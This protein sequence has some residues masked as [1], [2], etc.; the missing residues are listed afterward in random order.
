[1]FETWKRR[2]KLERELAKLYDH[3]A[4]QLKAA[5]TED[6]YR[7]AREPF[8]IDAADI[9]SELERLKTRKIRER[10]IKFGIDFPPFENSEDNWDEIP[11][12]S[13][14]ALT[15]KAQTKLAHQI[16][17]ARFAYWKQW[18]ELLVPILSLLVSLVLAFAA[19]KSK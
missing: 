19:L 14:R 18:A 17:V 11:Y 2:R 3:Y 12:S 1:M 7:E 13:S 4:P 8:D 15:E 5:R 10:A 9:V 16:S 6:D